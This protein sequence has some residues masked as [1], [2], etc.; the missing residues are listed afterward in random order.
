MYI[1]VKRTP[2]VTIHRKHQGRT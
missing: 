1:Y 2:L